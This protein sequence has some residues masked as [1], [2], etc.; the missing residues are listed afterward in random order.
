MK[1]ST[2]SLWYFS[3]G[4]L[5]IILEQFNSFL[6]ALIAKALMIPSLMWYFRSKIQG[7]PDLLQKFI[8]AGLF[9]SW[10]GDLLLQF[11]NM[12]ESPFLDKESWFLLG[13][14]AY[15]LTQVLYT[16]AFTLPKGKNTIFRRRIYQLFLVTAYGFLIIWL[17]YN[18]LG[19]FRVPVIIY[20]VAIL[21]MLTA[22]LNRYGKVNGVSYML[23]A[24]GALVFVFSDTM[25][26][27]THFYE[28][29]DFAR[30][31]I[32]VTYVA[33]QYLIAAGCLRQDINGD[34]A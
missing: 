32:M 10:L 16:V 23:V 18:R 15:F 2:F 25:I 6:P 17:I 34:S 28:K 3:I 9:F 1:Q 5:F 13:I 29:I 8:L 19:N 22:A 33:A 31:F 21:T 12:E 24:I 4:I 14:G 20:G 26:A 27:I 30:I 7:D 11:S